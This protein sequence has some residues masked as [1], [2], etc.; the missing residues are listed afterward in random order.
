MAKSRTFKVTQDSEI[1]R[2]GLSALVSSGFCGPPCDLSG[3]KVRVDVTGDYLRVG[4]DDISLNVG[5][6]N[7]HYLKLKAAIEELAA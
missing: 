7:R 1:G 5:P 6:D 4:L 2:L 3:L